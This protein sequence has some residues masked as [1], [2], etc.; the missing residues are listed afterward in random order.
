MNKDV[1]CSGNGIPGQ[2]FGVE[3]NEFIFG[4]ESAFV[5]VASYTFFYAATVAL[6]ATQFIYRYWA[7]FDACKLR[8]FKGFYWLF[9]PPFCSFFGLQ[10]AL[11]TFH[12]FEMDTVS[13]EYYRDEIQYWYGWN[14]SE[15]PA[16]A[17]VAYDPSNGMVRWKNVAG[18]INI[19]FIVISLYGIMMFCGWSMYFKMEEKIRNFSDELKK[20]QKQLFKTLVLQIT[21]PTIVLFTPLFVIILLPLFNPHV[22]LPSGAFICSFTLY[23]A[24]D[25]II[26]M[27]VVSQYR[28]TARK[29]C[30]DFRKSMESFRQ[31]R[32]TVHCSVPTTSAQVALQ[33][34]PLDGQSNVERLS[35]T[36]SVI[37]IFSE[38]L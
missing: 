2:A 36:Q 29:L 20:H 11:G 10:Y 15:I 14:I 19:V 4:N 21:A 33:Q 24:M 9:W 3:E 13:T 27:Y 25:S 17:L 22:S 6:L 38:D 18:V 23:P 26:V 12:L 16:M 34:D 31:S 7:I 32:A 28:Q 1:I 5:V 37:Q 35:D 8:Y 30:Q